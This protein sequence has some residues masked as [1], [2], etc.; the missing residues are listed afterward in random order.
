LQA[1]VDGVHYR[2]R[3]RRG[4]AGLQASDESQPHETRRCH[5]IHARKE[6]GRQLVR[7]SGGEVER[8]VARHRGTAEARLGNSDDRR[9]AGVDPHSSSDDRRIG[10][11][12]PRPVVV[13]EHR[14]QRPIEHVVGGLE[15]TPVNDLDA[16]HV[17]GVA[18]D[19]DGRRDFSAASRGDVDP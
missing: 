9:G 1:I 14:D 19:E 4:H 16:E 5:R 6:S 10:T 12:P 7:D 11:E 3:L 13:A 17:E 8:W 18:A 15:R 2:R